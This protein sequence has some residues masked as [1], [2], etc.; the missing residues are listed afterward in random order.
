MNSLLLALYKKLN[1]PKGLQL[2]VQRFINDQF[3]I[4]VTGVIFND[5][6]EVLLFKHTYRKVEWS[7]P[8]GYLQEK[9]HPKE[10]L[11]REIEEESGFRVKILKMI[12]SKHDIDSARLDMSYYGRF[13]GGEFKPSD[14]VIESRFFPKSKLP[15]LIDDQYKQIEEAYSRYKPS[16]VDNFM[17]VFA[18]I[19]RF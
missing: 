10:G 8:G 1:L 3:L 12:K 2:F 11:R 16:L 15:P 5:K 18:R 9:E 17:S 19:A 4:G 13:L 6:N 7:L 14:E